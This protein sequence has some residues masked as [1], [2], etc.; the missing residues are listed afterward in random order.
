MPSSKAIQS[1]W[2]L[3]SVA[4]HGKLQARKLFQIRRLESQILHRSKIKPGKHGGDSMRPGQRQL[5]RQTHV[6][7]AHLC[8]YRSVN[9]FPLLK[10]GSENMSETMTITKRPNISTLNYFLSLMTKTQRAAIRKLTPATI[11]IDD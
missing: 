1:R 6:G 3:S 7:N 11:I 2:K 5:N 4:V 9:K 8:N 10:L